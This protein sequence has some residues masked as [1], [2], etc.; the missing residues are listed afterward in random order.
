MFQWLHLQQSGQKTFQNQQYNSEKDLQNSGE[1]LPVRLAIKN[2]NIPKTQP[3][4]SRSR[5]N[6]SID[7]SEKGEWDAHV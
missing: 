5:V 4:G 1:D 3:W 6:C 7:I 2:K